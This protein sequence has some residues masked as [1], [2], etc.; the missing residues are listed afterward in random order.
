M[1][2]TFDSGMRRKLYGTPSRGT[3]AL[4]SDTMLY[5]GDLAI[6]SSLGA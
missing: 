5:A 2:E 3:L 6:V 4:G 1:N